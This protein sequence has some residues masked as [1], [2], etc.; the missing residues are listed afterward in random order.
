MRDSLGIGLDRD[1]HVP[2]VQ[3]GQADVEDDG[4]RPVV[5]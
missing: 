5:A 3:A 1:E 4:R 2:P